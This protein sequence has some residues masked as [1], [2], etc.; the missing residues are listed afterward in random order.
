MV[1]PDEGND[2]FMDLVKQVNRCNKNI[3]Q[4]METLETLV[5]KFDVK[6][7]PKKQR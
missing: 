3:T 5:H 2:K 6:V 4:M 7:E 1:N